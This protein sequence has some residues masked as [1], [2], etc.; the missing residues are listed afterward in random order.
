LF[1]L[2]WLVIEEKALVVADGTANKKNA[3]KLENLSLMG[4]QLRCV[5]A[6]LLRLCFF[7]KMEVWL[8]HLSGSNW[9]LGIGS[10]ISVLEVEIHSFFQ[11]IF[12]A[13]ISW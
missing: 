5:V 4:I 10:A 7:L 2:G 12:F 3:V 13:R 6:T 8:D 1:V 11:A 9:L